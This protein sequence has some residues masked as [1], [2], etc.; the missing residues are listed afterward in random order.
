M[1]HK[2]DTDYLINVGKRVKQ[3][4]LIKGVTVKELAKM[5]GYSPSK[6]YNIER[7]SYSPSIK[8]IKDIATFLD[9][10]PSFLLCLEDSAIDNRIVCKSIIDLINKKL[11]KFSI[12]D[13]K[14]VLKF[15]SDLEIS[16]VQW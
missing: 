1:S 9:V 12:E 15:I 4:R 11:E 13:L 10:S 3:G 8:D 2:R 16:N 5:M 7:G 6:L 14:K